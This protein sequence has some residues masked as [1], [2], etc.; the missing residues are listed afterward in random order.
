[1]R[2]PAVQVRPQLIPRARLLNLLDEWERQPG[3]AAEAVCLPSGAAA[4]AEWEWLPES[5]RESGTGLALVS[6]PGGMRA[7][8]APPFPIESAGRGTQPLREHMIRRRTVGIILLRLGH[9]AVCVGDDET[10]VSPKAGHRYVHGRHKAGGQSQHR[11]EHNREKWIRELYDEVCE[12]A[13]TRFREFAQPDRA[14][15]GSGVP[16]RAG[17]GSGRTIEWLA[18]GGDRIVL[19]GFLKRCD[20]PGG[21]NARILPWRVPVERPGADALADA[22]TAVWSSRFYVAPG[23]AA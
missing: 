22:V 19:S 12:V 9:Y 20:P 2:A 16:A 17:T 11:Y 10:A 6:H 21:L 4:G 13:T 15:R 3:G 23:P 5:A 14:G 7:A 1:M 8:I 18:L